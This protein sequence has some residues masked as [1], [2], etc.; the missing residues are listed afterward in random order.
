MKKIKILVTNITSDELV[1][2]TEDVA[3]HHIVCDHTAEGTDSVRKQA[4]MICSYAEY[5]NIM[6]NGYYELDCED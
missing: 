6:E 5:E 1:Q 2:H 4:L 3:L